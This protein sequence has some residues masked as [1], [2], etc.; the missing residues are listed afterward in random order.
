M[1]YY[2]DLSVYTYHEKWMGDKI[3][4][5]GWLEKNREFNVE[6][7]K[8]L[9]LKIVEKLWEQWNK[10][11]VKTRGFHVCDLCEHQ[12]FPLTLQDPNGNVCSVGSAEFRI[13]GKGG[14]VYAAPDMILHY[15][16]EHD[17]RPPNEF[18]DCILS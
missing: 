11:E 7:D 14:V 10:R 6:K 3:L 15:I 18:V 4:N 2:K 9:S 17:Y 1:T 13:L 8:T 5:I 12:E 16:L